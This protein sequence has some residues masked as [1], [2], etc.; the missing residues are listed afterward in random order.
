MAE[1]WLS[2]ARRDAVTLA[3]Q[4]IDRHLKTRPLE[5]G[6]SRELGR[7]VLLAP[8]LGVIY[9]VQANDLAV[10]VLRVWEFRSR[11]S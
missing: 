7:R 2:S 4:A 9:R 8:P 5:V 10:R 1:I 3:A 11:A 6:E